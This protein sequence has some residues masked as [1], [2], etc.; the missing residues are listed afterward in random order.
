MHEFKI[1]PCL[2]EITRFCFGLFLEKKNSPFKMIN[3]IQL[4]ERS[5]SVVEYLTQAEGLQVQA[6]LGSLNCVLE[7]D[8]YIL[9]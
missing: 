3:N 4:W 5:G 8:T 6:S 2:I 7:Q 9:A 1:N